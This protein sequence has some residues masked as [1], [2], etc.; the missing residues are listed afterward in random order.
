MPNRKE[1]RAMQQSGEPELT[2]RVTVRG[3]PFEIKASDISAK[4]EHDFNRMTD[5]GNGGMFLTDL[6]QGRVSLVHIAGLVW[7]MRRK[8]DKKLSLQ[9][10]EA[11]VN[12]Q[13][14]NTLELDDGKSDDENEGDE[15]RLAA[16]PEGNGA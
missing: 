12:L 7:V 6:F 15:P 1:R 2:I 5:S 9:D 8:Y 10:V 14:L 4:D 13:C 11:T 3:E 16:S